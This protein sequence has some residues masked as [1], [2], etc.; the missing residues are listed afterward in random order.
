MEYIPTIATEQTQ[1]PI[2]LSKSFMFKI[3]QNKNIE[4]RYFICVWFKILMS[5]N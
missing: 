4:G 1:D 5:T 2:K 3:V